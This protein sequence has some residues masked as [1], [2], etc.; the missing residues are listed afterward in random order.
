MS[1]ARQRHAE[2]AVYGEKIGQYTRLSLITAGAPRGPIVWLKWLTSIIYFL[3]AIATSIFWGIGQQDGPRSGALLSWF[4]FFAV[5]LLFVSAY[6][7]FLF[8][9]SRSKTSW[10][11]A[12]IL[13]SLGAAIATALF[14]ILGSAFWRNPLRDSESI[15]LT[16]IPLIAA[17]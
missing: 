13:H 10:Q 8:A 4:L 5:P 3:G 15:L 2:P 16:A 12:A 11:L 14:V 6:P 7:R 1:R 17:G 9:P